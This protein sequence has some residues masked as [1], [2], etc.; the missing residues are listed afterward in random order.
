MRLP[1]NIPYIEPPL[2]KEAKIA[3]DSTFEAPE[4]R[5]W[6]VPVVTGMSGVGKS[7]LGYELCRL[8]QN[9]LEL[10]RRVVGYIAFAKDIHVSRKGDKLQTLADA[11]V[12]A[13]VP[14]ESRTNLVYTFVDVMHSMQSQYGKHVSVVLHVDEYQQNIIALNELIRG[15][16]AASTDYMFKVIPIF[17]GIKPLIDIGKPTDTSDLSHTKVSYF[18]AH[19]PPLDA[20]SPALM[21]S[22]AT[23]IGVYDDV[24][25]GLNLRMLLKLCGGYPSSISVAV[26]EIRVNIKNGAHNTMTREGIVSIKELKNVYDR[27]VYREMH[28]F[29]QKRWE[30]SFGKG[31]H[32]ERVLMRLALSALCDGKVSHHFIS[33]GLKITLDEMSTTGL[34]SIVKSK[35]DTTEQENMND[36]REEKFEVILPAIAL[37]IMNSYL[38]II[39][40]DVLGNPFQEGFTIHERLAMCSIVMRVKFQKLLKNQQQLDMKQKYAQNQTQIPEPP[41][42][43]LLADLRPGARIRE[44]LAISNDL[45]INIPDRVTYQFLELL[46]KDVKDGA[47][48][49]NDS[50]AEVLP[51]DGTVFISALDEQGLDGGA[52]FSGVL[53]GKEVLVL[54]ISQSRSIKLTTSTRLQRHHVIAATRGLMKVKDSWI[55]KWIAKRAKSE[56]REILVIYDIFCEKEEGRMFNNDCVLLPR[57]I[58]L[59]D[60]KEA[61]ENLDAAKIEAAKDK[62]PSKKPGKAIVFAQ[63]NLDNATKALK[64]W[65]LQQ[66]KTEI[67]VLTTGNNIKTVIGPILALRTN[68]NDRNNVTSGKHVMSGKQP[69]NTSNKKKKS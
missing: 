6:R 7:R 36:E 46:L 35:P 15:C 40:I 21:N 62:K 23:A 20:M 59:N 34:L 11:L 12:L 47:V 61:N 55:A 52:L 32:V 43:M 41:K 16:V 1:L 3:L 60:V 42:T 18:R 58:L 25:L 69:V 66:L 22:F 33:G 9:S 5:Y 45:K 29:D 63:A 8:S 64:A 14:P 24:P 53:H 39:D 13:F 19:L 38:R 10:R 54:F 50:Q 2:L 56:A 27:I 44:N 17:T 28:R 26:S 49:Q 30:D 4:V 65:D 31:V 48:V 37:S 67:V 57:E 51:E 68:L